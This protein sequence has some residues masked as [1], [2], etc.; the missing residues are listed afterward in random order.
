MKLTLN[1][2][3]K[4]FGKVHV[5]HD[6]SFAVDSGRAMGFLGRNGSGKT[7]SIRCIMDIFK[8][9]SGEILLDDQPFKPRE[10]KVG[11]LPEERG[12]YAK[13][14]ILEQLIYFGQLKGGGK[15]ESKKSAEA[16]LER[17]EL[18]E[19][20]NKKLEVLSKG[21]QQ[22]I[23]IIQAFLNDPEMIILDEP[24]SGLDP[25]NAE[26]FKDAI[27]D[28]IKKDK[29]VIFS[30][31]QMGYVEE[32]CD[33]IT[34]IDKGEILINGSLADVKA[35]MSHDKYRLE[36]ENLNREQLKQLLKLF[37]AEYNN[38]QILLAS[39][40]KISLILDLSNIVP[41]D[42]LQKIIAANVQIKNFSI[43]LPTLTDVFL[44]YV[45]EHD[46][47]TNE[48]DKQDKEGN[49]NAQ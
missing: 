23:Q 5:L 19:Y 36:S 47:A 8:P 15:A 6:V 41:N 17:F 42:F 49:S 32:F 35:E 25:V 1:N 13:E 9:D 39:E 33:D 24:F 45:K 46:L 26:L 18:S 4:S 16:W 38:E 30:S 27:R 7:T 10:L 43:Y 34:L 37:E 48:M 28:A 12:M 29:L 20:A 21:N 3:N 2:I 22:K 31:H 11:Y 40:D 14:P 44:H